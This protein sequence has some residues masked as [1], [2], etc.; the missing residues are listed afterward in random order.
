MANA[1]RQEDKPKLTPKVSQ[2][3][4]ITGTNCGT[5][6][7]SNN[8]IYYFGMAFHREPHAKQSPSPHT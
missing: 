3:L 7:I 8:R 5:N 2:A 4:I 1:A 6:S